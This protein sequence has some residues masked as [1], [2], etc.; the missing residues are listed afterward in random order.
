MRKIRLMILPLLLP[1]VCMVS[2]MAQSINQDSAE[3][4]LTST[5]TYT[6]PF[7]YKL[8]IPESVDIGKDYGGG[9]GVH[10]V[11]LEDVVLPYNKMCMV[12]VDGGMHCTE[13]EVNGERKKVRRL[14][15][16]GEAEESYLIYSMKNDW[17][18]DEFSFYTP[19]SSS[20]NRKEVGTPVTETYSGRP[21]YGLMYF[22]VES[23]PE[24]PGEYQDL[25]TFT[26]FFGDYDW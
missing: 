24:Y 22:K 5:V 17:D 9:T 4:N 21:N 2:A 16:K 20:G 8:T 11:A 6:R 3:Q 13:V 1:L 10:Y 7:S 26:V 25:L 19:G 23:T 14:K 15:R 12:A 18:G